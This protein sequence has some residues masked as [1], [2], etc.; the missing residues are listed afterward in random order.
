MK[1]FILILAFFIVNLETSFG[2]KT[3]TGKI[4]DSLGHSI[5]NV[6]IG[7]DGSSS[8]AVSQPD[9]SF[10]IQIPSNI[11]SLN[12]YRSGDKVIEK[13]IVSDYLNVILPFQS[14]DKIELGSGEFID[15]ELN[16]E[17][18]YNSGNVQIKPEYPGGE[19]ALMEYIFKK[20]KYPVK[21]YTNKITG[22][23]YLRF[24]V[25]KTGDIGEILVMKS[26]HP[27][28]DNEAIR[29]VRSMPAWK[30]GKI[31]GLPVD[32]WFIIPIKFSTQ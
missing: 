1:T 25:T 28:L 10:S 6:T 18:I 12:F 16:G 8:F 9:G 15:N 31:D 17:N 27:L 7:F 13:D 20:L 26:A 19:T 14:A 4:T 11:R 24:V 21:A 29:V 23:V 2:Q 32:V 30:P 3:I 5:P 22:T